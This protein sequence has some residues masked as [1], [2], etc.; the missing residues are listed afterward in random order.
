MDIEVSD[1]D[2]D[3]QNQHMNNLQLNG[4]FDNWEQVEKLVSLYSK[5]AL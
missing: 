2:F 5:E 4:E 1:A 3:S